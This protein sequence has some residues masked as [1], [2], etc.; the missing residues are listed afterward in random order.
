MYI[1]IVFDKESKRKL[2]AVEAINLYLDGKRNKHSFTCTCGASLEIVFFK[3][4]FSY[5]FRSIKHAIHNANCS[6][7][8]MVIINRV[9]NSLP[10]RLYIQP[11][12][13]LVFNDNFVFTEEDNKTT[14]VVEDTICV[15]K[16][17]NLILRPWLTSGQ[18][19]LK[20]T[21]TMHSIKDLLSRAHSC[22]KYYGEH[23]VEFNGER[24]RYRDIFKKTGSCE[25]IIEGKINIYNGYVSCH[26]LNDELILKFNNLLI[27]NSRAFCY[28][29]LELSINADDFHKLSIEKKAKI[30][31]SEKRERSFFINVIAKPSIASRE[32]GNTIYIKLTIPDGYLNKFIEIS[33]SCNLPNFCQN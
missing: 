33:E 24:R 31:S 25:K 18:Q 10:S 12:E 3:K 32:D 14:I 21:A 28:A 1:Q 16:G 11:R 20:K 17:P 30:L 29:E 15:W 19:E 26:Y 22:S 9:D 4:T 27:S 5:Y 8:K 2:P 6:T 13:R 7:P 23:Y